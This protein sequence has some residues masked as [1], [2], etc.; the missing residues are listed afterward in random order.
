MAG[1]NMPLTGGL[2]IWGQRFNKTLVEDSNNRH[3]NTIHETR[4]CLTATYWY[5]PWDR[6]RIIVIYFVLVNNSESESK[7][8]TYYQ[9]VQSNFSLAPFTNMV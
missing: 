6:L 5:G 3:L 7:P 4:Q 8:E 2:Q 9:L 1:I